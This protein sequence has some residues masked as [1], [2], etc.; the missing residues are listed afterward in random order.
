MLIGR[1]TSTSMLPI[2]IFA[3]TYLSSLAL[4]T[5][6]LSSVL[7]TFYPVFLSLF[8]KFTYKLNFAFVSDFYTVFYEIGF[9]WI[10]LENVISNVLNICLVV[11][12]SVLASV[13]DK[14]CFANEYFTLHWLACCPKSS[15]RKFPYLS[16]FVRL[17]IT[18]QFNPSSGY[19]PYHLTFSQ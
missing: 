10:A 9:P 16:S 18:S 8:E 19:F 11:F 6:R 13:P 7:F 3:S 12:T 15:I 2:P 4:S 17:C 14:Y 5:S 1:C